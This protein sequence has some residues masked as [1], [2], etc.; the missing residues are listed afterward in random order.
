MFPLRPSPTTLSPTLPPQPPTALHG[1]S[2][3]CYPP[4]RPLV[5][6]LPAGPNCCHSPGRHGNTLPLPPPPRSSQA[7]PGPGNAPQPAR[8]LDTRPLFRFI[9]SS[10]RPAG[11]PGLFGIY[12]KLCFQEGFLLLL[13]KK[14][15]TTKHSAS[16]SLSLLIYYKKPFSSQ[17]E[18]SLLPFLT[19]VAMCLSTQDQMQVS[20]CQ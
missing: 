16:S 14:R 10:R 4:T 9:A 6:W 5:S 12:I 8:G 19:A 2:G 7:R 18:P 17:P 15:P 3:A 13:L 1:P 20:R 11:F